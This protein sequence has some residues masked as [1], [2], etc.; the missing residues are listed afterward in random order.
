MT[1]PQTG[2]AANSTL[3][4]PAW[5]RHPADL[6]R[7]VVT[8]VI[9][10][11]LVGF[12]RLFGTSI[13]NVSSSLIRLL[14]TIPDGVTF[15]LV[16]TVQV[17]VTV[18]I[19]GA[20]LALVIKRRWRILGLT[21]LAA[22]SG[23]AAMAFLERYLD[24][25][26]PAGLERSRVIESWL[27]GS[28]YPS[29]A[30]LA[31]GAAVITASAPFVPR[32][33]Y[34]VATATIAGVALLRVVSA[35][36]VP[37]NLLLIL[38]VGA[39]MGSIALVI[40]GAPHRRIDLDTITDTLTGI[41]L[42]P[43]QIEHHGE[44]R[45][46]PSF[47]V[48]H[49][50]TPDTHVVLLG[51][52]QRDQDLVLRAWRAMRLKGFHSRR[53]A[54][55]PRRAAEHEQ[56]VLALARA[57]GATTAGPVAVGLTADEAALSVSTWVEGTPLE[58][59]APE[60]VDDATLT[61]LWRHVARLRAR[62]IAHG[63][64]NTGSIH[65]D[66]G[67]PTIVGFRWSTTNAADQMLAADAAEL[68]SSLA[69]RFG[70]DRAV[71]GA[72]AG[73]GAGAL[74]DVLPLLQPLVVSSE[75]RDALK[76]AEIKIGDVRDALQ[77]AVGADTVE[78]APLNR[79]SLKGV[80]SLVGSIVLASYIFSL[81]SDWRSIADAF[82]LMNWA[83][84]PLLVALV[85]IG[86]SGGALSMMGSVNVDLPF[87]R[88]SQIMFA[89]GFLN[90]FTPANAGGMALRA[91]YLQ[92]EGV[93]LT[94]GAAAVGLTSA[95]SGLFQAIL[96]VVFLLWG[97]AADQLSRF[98]MPSTTKLLGILIG[99]GAVIGAIV[100]SSWGKRVVV[101]KVKEL[102]GPA[103]RSFVELT[104]QPTKLAQLMGGTAL[105]K[106]CT[107]ISFA[108]CVSAMGVDMSFA[109]IGA[110]YMVANTIGAAVPTPGGVGGI[111]AALT[112]ALISGGVDAPTAGAIVL[113]FRLFTFWFPTVP[114]WACLQRAQ[115]SGIV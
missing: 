5:E 95:V 96:I 50:D 102:V 69:V 110:L 51:R 33:W 10:I 94:V 66:D 83:A 32:A 115:R 63:W 80:V 29:A 15:A 45:N 68:L 49:G 22:A 61:E 75:T 89:Q 27:G 112:A 8:A 11:G 53:P 92:R 13:D 56:L 41:G 87:M 39:C 28:A 26:L 18:A 79:V 97:G 111:E 93:D 40:I 91:R 90:R 109:R 55:S 60:S 16:G 12:S 20:I 71:A 34:R 9:T 47:H 82:G 76:S 3:R 54:G 86:N 36:E 19:P 84:V 38:A 35:T 70:I 31:A 114:G 105:G 21:V 78:L 37:M 65:V 67:R 59:L 4:E 98:S 7:L 17:V 43:T 103:L 106:M 88:T 101:P 23:G 2:A 52:D 113:I 85:L 48:R 108:V 6:A 62:R 77:V 104:R 64:L 25:T 42:A 74:T 107:I 1:A 57:S 72:L 30:L 99:V 44:E 58:Q 81:A 73:M 24:S 46:A 100:L 14:R